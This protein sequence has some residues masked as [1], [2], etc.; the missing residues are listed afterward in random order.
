MAYQLLHSE[1]ASVL[2]Q[3]VLVALAW[4]GSWVIGWSIFSCVRKDGLVANIVKICENDHK[5]TNLMPL[6]GG[7]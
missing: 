2:W 7:A 5:L 4:I 1:V 6:E 3:A